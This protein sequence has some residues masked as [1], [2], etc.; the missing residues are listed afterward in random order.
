MAHSIIAFVPW[1]LQW[2]TPWDL[3]WCDTAKAHGA[4]QG[5]CPVGVPWYAPRYDHDTCHN[6]SH[7]L[8]MN[9]SMGDPMQ[10]ALGEH[11]CI[12]AVVTPWDAPWDVS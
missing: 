11:G 10:R 2:V 1:L 3:P 4:L 8:P 9:Y 12:Y 5:S 7:G 6:L